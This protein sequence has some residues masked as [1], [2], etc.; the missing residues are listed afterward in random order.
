MSNT[1]ASGIEKPKHDNLTLSGYRVPSALKTSGHPESCL[2]L[3]CFV[4]VV[5]HRTLSLRVRPKRHLWGFPVP[6]VESLSLHQ[7]I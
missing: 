2:V 6:C 4:M 3:T 7:L 5:F 1:M